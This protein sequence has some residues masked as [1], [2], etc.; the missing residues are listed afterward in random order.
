MENTGGKFRADRFCCQLV[1]ALLGVINSF[2]GFAASFVGC[3][4]R[5]DLQQVGI[6]T[7][8]DEQLCAWIGRRGALRNFFEGLVLWLNFL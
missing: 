1:V 7:K 2:G 6:T 5:Y 3:H 4:I 8:K